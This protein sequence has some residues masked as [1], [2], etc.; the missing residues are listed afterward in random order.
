MTE[1]SDNK[2]TLSW[3]IASL[4]ITS[5]ILLVFM[6]FGRPGN[7]RAAW[8]CAVAISLATRFRWELSGEKWFWP[9]IAA[10]ALIHLPLIFLFPWS[11]AWVPSFVIFPF[12]LVDIFLILVLIHRVELYLGRSKTSKD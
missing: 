7:G 12:V 9:S 10:I 2:V 11:A 3:A 4:L 1:Q 6:Y 5:P 8:F